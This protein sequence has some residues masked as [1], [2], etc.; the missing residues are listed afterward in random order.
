MIKS[1][2]LALLTLQ[3]GSTPPDSTGISLRRGR[4][5]DL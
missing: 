1:L 2:A 3:G 5:T 4:E